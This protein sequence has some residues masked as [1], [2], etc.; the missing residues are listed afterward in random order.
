MNENIKNEIQKIN[1]SEKL[2]P[3][4][5]RLSESVEK[6]FEEWLKNEKANSILDKK[7]KDEAIRTRIRES[8][9]VILPIKNDGYID[10]IIKNK[11]NKD[12]DDGKTKVITQIANAML[13]GGTF[14]FFVDLFVDGAIGTLG[15]ISLA[16]LGGIGGSEIV[17]F[18]N[19]TGLYPELSNIQK[20]WLEERKKEYF[21]YLMEYAKNLVLEEIDFKYL[22]DILEKTNKDIELLKVCSPSSFDFSDAG[23][24]HD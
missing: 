16:S 7:V 5:K 2:D 24:Q 20:E 19:A 6:L 1:D 18:L 14:L 3:E 8:Y 17:N 23:E 21:N 11:L 4:Q 15:M 12:L 9:K 10:D 22:K 13:A